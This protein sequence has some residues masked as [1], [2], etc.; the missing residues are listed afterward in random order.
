M[1]QDGSQVRPSPLTINTIHIIYRSVVSR[2]QCRQIMKLS[3]SRGVKIWTR[4]RK[5]GHAGAL[6]KSREEEHQPLQPS[7]DIW[8]GDKV[9]GG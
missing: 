2:K 8:S 9:S 7:Q 1:E 6:R 3:L 4:R 5:A